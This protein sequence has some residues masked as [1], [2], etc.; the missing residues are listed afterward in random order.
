MAALSTYWTNTVKNIVQHPDIR[1]GKSFTL[2][3]IAGSRPD[4]AIGIAWI[5][6]IPHRNGRRPVAGTQQDKSSS[7]AQE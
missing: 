2:L 5:A 6:K 4:L 7:K 1:F 3:R